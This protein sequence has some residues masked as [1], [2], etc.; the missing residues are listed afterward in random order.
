MKPSFLAC[1]VLLLATAPI[2]ATPAPDSSSEPSVPAAAR[3]LA[4]LQEP[5][6]D[7]NPW[8]LWRWQTRAELDRLRDELQTRFPGPLEQLAL[9]GGTAG[10]EPGM[11]ERMW[12]CLSETD[13]N[14]WRTSDEPFL[15]RRREVFDA[16]LEYHARHNLPPSDWVIANDPRQRPLLIGLAKEGLEVPLHLLSEADWKKAEPL[17]R[18]HLNGPARLAALKVLFTRVTT[19]DEALVGLLEIARSPLEKA[20]RRQQAIETLLSYP[21]LGRSDFL[22]ETLAWLQG[23]ELANS[24]EVGVCSDPAFF[25]P[26]LIA[27]LDSEDSVVRSRA[28]LCLVK[29][30]TR[31]SLAPLVPWLRERDWKELWE[32]ARL[33]Y[34]RRLADVPVEEAIPG[35]IKLVDQ[36]EGSNYD[37]YW[38]APAVLSALRNQRTPNA[39]IVARRAL[40]RAYASLDQWQALERQK[41]LLMI[42]MSSEAITIQ[43]QIQGLQA[44]ADA[45]DGSRELDMVRNPSQSRPVFLG[46]L[47][48]KHGARKAVVVALVSRIESL[49]KQDRSE[50]RRLEA[51]L[52]FMRSPVIDGYLLDRLS[53]E[54]S[55]GPLLAALL[56]RRT[57]LNSEA[58]KRLHSL[59]LTNGVPRG[60]ACAA[61]GDPVLIGLCLS[62]GDS[63]AVAA[64]L[65]GGRYLDLQLDV[66]EVARRATDDP[67]LVDFATAYLDLVETE[68]A[69][70]LS[71]ALRPD[72]RILGRPSQMC[73][74]SQAELEAIAALHS[75][76][77]PEEIYLLLLGQPPWF[78]EESGRI[79][80]RIE[81]HV[82]K[83]Q[84]ML[85]IDDHPPR[86]LSPSEFL[87][88]RE[89]LREVAA[90]ALPR[91]TPHLFSAAHVPP[92]PTEAEYLHLTPQGGTRVVFLPTQ[93]RRGQLGKSSPS[94][95][96]VFRAFDDLAPQAVLKEL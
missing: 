52:T 22:A 2:S 73:D 93:I 95:D 26:R 42:G 89:T 38:T 68:E 78:S 40:E 56:D 62:R 10:L 5:D 75:H 36:T 28:A 60:I 34:I 46:E 54:S 13:T 20:E 96:A 11:R 49:R 64:L 66:R 58:R 16:V 57:Y 72:G 85:W 91:F 1:I 4:A 88:F 69:H 86:T 80:R 30:G 81:I 90:D 79:T 84:A 45:L 7:R 9:P 65:A 83:G 12:A 39:Q 37:S 15:P 27:A 6:F 14:F 70:R 18:G 31:E 32:G 47:L 55:D 71:R 53:K 59:T 67:A 48:V 63:A 23:E 74:F 33:A 17:I 77:S 44:L 24:V 21:W 82:S 51:L 3:Q 76:E 19:R 35:L 92:A 41:E 8:S 29:V 25:I 87:T 43:E 94:H 50:A 61:L